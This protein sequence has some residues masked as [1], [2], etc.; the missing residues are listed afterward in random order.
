MNHQDRSPESEQDERFIARLKE[1]DK[2]AFNDLVAKTSE[3][4]Y[5]LNLRLVLDADLAEDLTQ[6]AYIRIYQALPGFKGRS[7]L[8]TW[9]YRI[10]YNVA[11]SEL[12][13][14]KYRREIDGVD[15][16]RLD[17]IRGR[18]AEERSPDPLEAMERGETRH[19]VS[20]LINELKPDQRWALTLYYP[21]EKSYRE[22]SEIMRL[23]MGTVKTLLFRAKEELRKKISIE[24]S[25]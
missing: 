19:R 11:M 2:K 12:Q 9:I 15:E 23:P 1:Q 4:V 21:G 13:K 17:E 20:R 22:I 16:N 10:A 6:E 3:M 24:D 18:M 14:A 25:R 7:S 8:S 5:N